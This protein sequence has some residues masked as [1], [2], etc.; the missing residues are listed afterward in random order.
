ML[1]LDF[2]ASV[3]TDMLLS[4]P[5]NVQAAV[6]ASPSTLEASTT[7]QS[8]QVSRALLLHSPSVPFALEDG[9]KLN[10]KAVIY[11]TSHPS[12]VVQA[13]NCAYCCSL[14]V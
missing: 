14:A 9:V 11:F 8:E 12:R 5:Q 2:H 4:R 10:L 3:D 13:M 1:F 6:T 7:A